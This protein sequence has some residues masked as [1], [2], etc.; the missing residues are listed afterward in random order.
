MIK[1][2]L[3]YKN[4]LSL[5][6]LIAQ[7]QGF[8]KK[9]KVDVHIDSIKAL[10]QFNMDDITANVGD[11]TRILDKALVGDDLLITSDL[12]E[13]I[14]LILCE[15]YKEKKE[16]NILCATEQSLGIYT[17]YF[18]NKENLNYNLISLKDPNKRYDMLNNNTV[19]GACLIE[20]FIH[21]QLKNGYKV[22]FEAKNYKHNYTCWAFKKDYATKEPKKVLAFH[23]SLNEA[24]TYFNSLSYDEKISYAKKL[25]PFDNSLNNLYG[26]MIFTEDKEYIFEDLKSAYDWKCEKNKD[27]KNININNMIFKW[28]K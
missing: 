25:T 12:T 23:K 24:T 14:K 16:L 13:T 2:K 22:V 3:L 6:P 19:D 9:N 5:Q 1:L 15:D 17:E 26:N 18:L 8:F 28:D 27:Y 21:P 7:D 4:P 11:V 20:P 10:P